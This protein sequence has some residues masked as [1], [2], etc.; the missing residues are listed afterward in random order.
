MCAAEFYQFNLTK[1]T[2]PRRKSPSYS[3][4][5]NPHTANY[6]FDLNVIKIRITD[7][8]NKIVRRPPE[9]KKN[10]P[11]RANR[12]LCLIRAHI[13]RPYSVDAELRNSLDFLLIKLS[14]KCLPLYVKSDYTE[15]DSLRRIKIDKT[16]FITAYVWNRIIYSYINIYI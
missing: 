4:L 6:L 10:S 15:K 9:Y 2:K 7:G 8:I 13:V 12:L 11:L 1:S 14:I 5:W 16:S 3:H